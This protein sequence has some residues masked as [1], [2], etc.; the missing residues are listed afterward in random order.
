MKRG[1]FTLVEVMVALAIAGLVVVGAYRI[2]AGVA[3]A[4]RAIGT[5]REDLD[6]RANARRWLKAAFLSLEPP[7]EGHID[8]VSFT[9]WQLGVGGWLE[10]KSI[11]AIGRDAEKALA[12][13][14][15][16]YTGVRHPAH[17]GKTQ[18][19]RQISTA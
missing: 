2:F 8:R 7:F 10:P 13:S 18:F 12:G 15:Y 4:T 17:G 5:A 16:A 6:R 1:G 9:S 19:L 14:G 3:D 11:V